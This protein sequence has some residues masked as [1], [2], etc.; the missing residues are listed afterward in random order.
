[1]RIRKM[2]MI[3]PRCRERFLSLLEHGPLAELGVRQAGLS[4]L[5]GVYY[6]S[7]PQPAFYLL[8]GTLAGRARLQLENGARMLTAGTVCWAP[9]GVPY[10]YDTLPGQRWRIIWFHFQ[11]QP[12]LQSFKDLTVMPTDLLPKLAVE[13]EDI[14]RETSV[15]SRWSLPARRAKE[16][17]VAVIIQRLLHQARPGAPGRYDSVLQQLWQKVLGDLR[18]PWTLA[19]CAALAGFSAGHLNR[20][21]RQAYGRPA[22]KQLTRLRLEHAEQSL[23]R[24][25]LKIAAIAAQCGYANAFAFSVAFKRQFGCPPSRLI[26]ASPG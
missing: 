13:T 24:G 25:E 5:Q 4:D 15:V 3:G 19:D 10:R 14:L 17:Y 8:L 26:P 23:R 21:C 12:W 22:M 20:I 16:E 6:M 9:A 2:H 18:R 11:P 1:M 7:R